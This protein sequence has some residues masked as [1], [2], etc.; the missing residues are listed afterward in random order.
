MRNTRNKMIALLGLLLLGLSLFQ[1]AHASAGVVSAPVVLQET[2]GTTLR[3]AHAQ[4]DATFGKGIVPL[5]TAPAYQ[6]NAAVASGVVVSTGGNLY[7]SVTAGT[8]GASSA[9]TGLRQSSDGTVTW[10]GADMFMAL[11]ANAYAPTITTGQANPSATLPTALT[12]GFGNTFSTLYGAQWWSSG[13]GTGCTSVC[14]P[15]TLQTKSGT[16]EAVYYDWAFNTDA[17]KLAFLPTTNSLPYRIWIDDQMYSPQNLFS[18]GGGGTWTI[19]DWSSLGIRRNHKVEIEGW[20]TT[21]GGDTNFYNTVRVSKLDQVWPLGANDAVRGAYIGDSQCGGSSY[22]T[23]DIGMSAFTR[24]IGIRDM[25]AFCKGGTGY[26]NQGAGNAFY[27]YGQRVPQVLAMNPAPKIVFFEGSSNDAG[28]GASAITTA[29]LAA[30]Q[31]LADGGYKG[32]IVVIGVPPMPSQAT[33]AATVEGALQT[34]ITQFRA[35]RSNT[36]CFIPLQSGPNGPVIT[37]TGS[38][39][40]SA[41]D[42][43]ADLYNSDGTHGT[44]AWRDYEYQQIDAGYKTNCLPNIP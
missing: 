3:R 44:D 23:Y 18:T 20:N 30:W 19:I 1:G 11:S 38:V 35:S 28:S 32:P 22:T 43:N 37:G 26:I 4:A 15:V 41:S 24:R 31:A 27:T 21:G 36:I 9:P 8:T 42:G 7:Q 40:T 13:S 14:K 12:P 29:A 6:A 17:Q 16:Y 33:N 2:N 34:A 25:W 10:V 5:T 39:A